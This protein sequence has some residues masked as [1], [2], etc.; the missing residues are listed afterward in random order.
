[1]SRRLRRS[2]LTACVFAL[3]GIG[4]AVGSHV[5]GRVDSAAVAF[6]VLL[7]VGGAAAAYLDWKSE[8]KR[9]RVTV[10]SAAIDARRASR[11]QIGNNN[12]QI[13]QG[14]PARDRH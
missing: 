12:V 8:A 13:N 1:M 10:P 6:V 3:A 14:D 4:G 2:L 11:F 9:P 7:M 5:T